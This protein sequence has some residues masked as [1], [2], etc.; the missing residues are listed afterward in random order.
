MDALFITVLRWGVAGA[1]LATM[2]SQSFTAAV[3]VVRLLRQYGLWKVRWQIKGEIL[4]RILKLGFPLGIQSMILTLSNLFVQFYINGFG[5]DAVAAFTVYF[6][7]ENLIYLPIMAFGQAMVTFTGQ[8]TG[9][10]KKERI[11]QGA[12][13]CNLF[14]AAVIFCISAVVLFLGRP[15]L[16]LFCKEEEV[17]EEGLRIIRIS[18]PFYF[19]YAI[20][21]VTGG[22]VRG[23][24]KTLQSMMIVIMNLCVI[25][26]LLLT[27]LVSS[28]HTVQAVAAVYPLTWAL[29]AV[30]FVGYYILLFCREKNV[31]K[32]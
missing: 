31:E 16:G 14:S 5:E 12:L 22:I 7:V 28:F 15:I 11:R 29:A 3:L 30:S 27:F 21:E 4:R 32:M 13:Q 25:R 10:G 19:I 2:V 23:M 9:A 24:G 20:L 18:F 17:I 26:V 1:A 6:K 8:N